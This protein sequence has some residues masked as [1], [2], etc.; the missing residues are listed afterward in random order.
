MRC[1]LMKVREQQGYV[2]QLK[3]F[4]VQNSQN[5]SVMC[6]GASLGFACRLPFS[7]DLPNNFLV[8]GITTGKTAIPTTY[9]LCIL[10]GNTL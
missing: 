5:I 7:I 6:K 1:M 10:K 3:A 8:A 9:M 4:R 2:L